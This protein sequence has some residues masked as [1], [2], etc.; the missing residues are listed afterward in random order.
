MTRVLVA[1]T[2]GRAVPGGWARL[3]GRRRVALIRIATL[4]RVAALVGVTLARRVSGLAL[5]RIAAGFRRGILA[6]G[7]LAMLVVLLTSIPFV[8]LLVG[9][10]P[11]SL[12]AAVGRIVAHRY[13]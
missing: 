9:G 8:V 12:A 6:A 7:L 3:I 2:G 5:R 13:S 4:L 1:A 10:P 11:L